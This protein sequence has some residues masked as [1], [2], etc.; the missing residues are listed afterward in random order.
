MGQDSKLTLQKPLR[1]WPG[2]VIVILQWVL[3]FGVPVVQPEALYVGVMAGMACGPLVLIW[4]L[5]FSRAPWLDRIG[6]VVLMTAALFVT[7][8]IAHKSISTGAMGMLFYLLVI[9]LLSLAFVLWAVAARRLSAVPRRVSMVATIFIACGVFGLIRTGGFTGDFD[10]DL[11]WRW[12]ETPEERLL[13]EGEKLPPPLP[14]SPA[15]E[16][17]PELPEASTAEETQEEEAA[18]GMHEEPAAPSTEPVETKREVEAITEWPG[19]RGPNRDSVIRGVRIQTDWSAHPPVEMWRRPI[20]PG[21]SSF[22][23]RGDFL[24][25]QEQ[26]GE[27]E[28]VVCYNITTGEPVWSHSDVARFW[29]SNG[30][31]GPRGT[32]TLHGDRLYSFGATGI[33]NALHAVDGT[34]VWSRN[35]AL[36]TGTKIPGW[37]FASSPL[38]EDDLVIV[39]VAGQLAAYDLDTGEPR[40]FGPKHGEDYSSPHPVTIDGVAQIVLMSG[41]GTTS[42]APNNG[43]V[44]WE[45]SLP[46][47]T[48]IVQPAQTAD[49]DILVSEGDQHGMRRI[50]VANGPDGWSIKE[51]WRSIGLKPYFNDFVIHNDHAFGFDGSFLSC[52][53]LEDGERRWK[54]GRYGNG[55]LILLAD[56]DII[57]VLSEK[58]ELALVGAKTDQ[59]TEFARHPAI[60]GKTWNHPVLVRNILLVRNAREMAAF[61]LSLAN[62]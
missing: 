32:P 2:V 6:A 55:Q 42:V 27:D 46:Q 8:Y 30:G 13:A 24:Y 61:R 12:S 52:I 16:E 29:E 19:F 59:F 22:A 4:W 44:L 35:A 39:A 23:V 49:G 62:D 45:H 18:S 31:A 7:P 25:T 20:G 54:E 17:T 14:P 3:R 53:N 48:R 33:L 11:A 50:A 26:R 34:L 1:V 28:L 43:T 10:H 47:G 51:R 5:F 58:G 15:L 38:I 37:G 56:Q 41:S 40:W 60:E 36:D 21:W 9:P 57:L